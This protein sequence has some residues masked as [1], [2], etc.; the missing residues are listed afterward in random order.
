MLERASGCSERASTKGPWEVGVENVGGG[1]NIMSGPL[2]V[3]HTSIQARVVR[4]DTRPILED[5]VKANGYLVSAAPEMFEALTVARG[6]LV[7]AEADASMRV[8]HV[9]GYPGLTAQAQAR[10]GDIRRDIALVDASLA[11]A[12]GRTNLADAT[13]KNPLGRERS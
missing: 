13:P 10:L 11:K 4:P 6:Y 8:E 9:Q 1:F 5:E 2:R 7:E 3:A 12:E